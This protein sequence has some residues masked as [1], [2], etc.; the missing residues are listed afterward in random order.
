MGEDW[1]RTIDDRKNVAWLHFACPGLFG[2]GRRRVVRRARFNQL[3]L[4]PALFRGAHHR[5]AS[6]F[7]DRPFAGIKHGL[8]CVALDGDG[9]LARNELSGKYSRRL[10]RQL[11]VYLVT[12]QFLSADRG[13]R[14]CGRVLD[15]S[16]ETCSAR[17]VVKHVARN[18]PRC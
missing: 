10:D 14:S 3:A 11:L 4:G 15:P 2:D 7:A 12:R 6:F 9:D 13:S 1:A 5:R 18:N 17:C 8:Q 16:C